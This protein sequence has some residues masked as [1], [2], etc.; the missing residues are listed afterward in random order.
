MIESAPF[1]IE[2]RDPCKR[3]VIIAN[4]VPNLTY[5]IGSKD[6]VNQVYEDFKDDISILYGNGYYRCGLREHYITDT[7][8]NKRV[9]AGTEV[10][11]VTYVGLLKISSGDPLL[12]QPV[13]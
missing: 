7:L 5:T 13:F 10:G 3:A 11:A 8:G 9:D 2:Y 4:P 12:P 6:P 1:T